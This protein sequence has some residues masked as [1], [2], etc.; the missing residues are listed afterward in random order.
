MKMLRKVFFVT[1]ILLVTLTPQMISAQDDPAAEA[2]GEGAIIAD[3]GFRASYNGFGFPNYGDEFGYANLTSTEMIRIFGDGVCYTAVSDLGECELIPNAQMWMEE[4]NSYMAGGHC[5]GMAVLSAALFAGAFDPAFFGADFPTDLVLDGN[6]VLQREIALWWALQG[7]SP[8]PDTGIYGTPTEVVSALVDGL[9]AGELYTIGIYAPD[10]TGGHAI[11][12]YAVVDMG[13]GFYR[14]L[15]YDNNYPFEERFIELD[16]NTDS[17]VYTGS[18][19][20]SEPETGYYGDA[21]TQTLSIYT[22]ASRFEESLCPFCGDAAMSGAEGSYGSLNLNGYGHMVVTDDQGNQ[23]GFVNGA[24]VTNIPGSS[25]RYPHNGAARAPEIRIPSNVVYNVQITSDPNHPDGTATQISVTQ[26]G[27]VAH[28]SGIELGDIASI[29]EFSDT[30]I[31][32]TSGSGDEDLVFE[33]GVTSADGQNFHFVLQGTSSELEFSV[34]PLTGSFEISGG[35]T[36]ATFTLSA[37]V[38]DA[39]GNLQ[40]FPLLEIT[41]TDEGISFAPADWEDGV[42]SES[43]VDLDIDDT[44]DDAGDDSGAD[45][46]DDGADDT[47]S[48]G[49]SGDDGTAD[50]GGGDEGGGDEGGEEGE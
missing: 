28:L 50:E 47:G 32:Y 37:Q 6:D 2:V 41:V 26:Q 46:G 44:G 35:E 39:D 24:Y 13:D 36:P 40:E 15:V 43:G 23:T 14:I 30:S 9:N 11:T 5:E 45:A 7:V 27:K 25:I 3:A 18:T 1:T 12:P 4:T 16:A 20:P 42:I 8:V 31:D 10:G 19:N 33:Q 49:D 38:I 21:S 22:I 34:D 17:W 48:D 29:L